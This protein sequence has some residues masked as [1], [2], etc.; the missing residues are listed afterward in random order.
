MVTSGGAVASATVVA[1]AGIAP[2][3]TQEPRRPRSVSVTGGRDRLESTASGHPPVTGM[4]EPV[5]I[6]TIG[7]ATTRTRRP[8]P[9]SRCRARCRDGTSGRQNRCPHRFDIRVGCDLARVRR[10]D[11]SVAVEVGRFV[12]ARKCGVEHDQVHEGLARGRRDAGALAAI[13]SPAFTVH[14][15]DPVDE[16]GQSVGPSQLVRSKILRAQGICRFTQSRVEC[17]TLRRRD[18][19]EDSAHAVLCRADSDEAVRLRLLPLGP[20]PCRVEPCDDAVG[21]I[22]QPAAGQPSSTGA[23]WGQNLFEELMFDLADPVI[24]DVCR[25]VVDQ[26]HPVHV[27]ITARHGLACGVQSGT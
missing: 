17:A 7:S 26:A 14:E 25:R 27:E 16:R 2:S 21:G 5:M 11:D 19:T 4:F 3:G 13:D 12:A 6:S 24:A 22:R 23:K 1:S 10:V 18:G 8:A 20:H 15:P 9:A